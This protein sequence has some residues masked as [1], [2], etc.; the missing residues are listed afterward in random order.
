MSQLD[1]KILTYIL[2]VMSCTVHASQQIISHYSLM[3]Y[4]RLMS[5]EHFSAGRPVGVVLSLPVKG[6]P[7]DEL[8]YLIQELHKSGRWPILVY[9]VSSDMKGN[10][11][12][13][14]NKQGAYIILISGPCE[15][16]VEYISR[17]RQQ[18]YGL[19]ADEITEQ[20]FNPR[21]KF[22][23][24]LMSNCEQKEN[25]E[26]SR[27]VLN[28]LWLNEVMKATVLFLKFNER[29]SKNDS[30]KSTYMEIHNL[31]H[32]ENAQACNGNED[33][34][35]LKV[36]TAQNFNERRD[37]FQNYY[38]KNFY[39]SQIRVHAVT[40]SPFVNYPKRFFNNH[41]PCKERYEGGWETE[42]LGV[43]EKSL[44]MSLDIEIRNK[45]EQFN[46]SPDIFVG[47][48]SALPLSKFNKMNVTRNYLT[49]TFV[50]Y[51]PCAVQNKMW[52]RFFNIFFVDVW[53]CFAFSL[54]LAVFT[55]RCISR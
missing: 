8:E 26:F 14:T 39:K 17:F 33:T 10:M 47:G 40:G 13:E 32:Y 18:V 16:W 3:H 23:V 51:T 9:N 44:N 6:S 41:S 36:H 7:W 19:S 52:S 50:W 22:F 55:V 38:T 43:V 5:E 34:L 30:V 21:V 27:A 35:P 15:K 42:L 31:Y 24:S 37:T 20:S 11:Y 49:N 12:S 28:E 25:T 45:T 4:T 1:M 2:A 54:V 46:S 48:F 53:V 29:G